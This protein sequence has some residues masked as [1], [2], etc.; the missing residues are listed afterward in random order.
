MLIFGSCNF[1]VSVK[2]F[3]NCFYL[4]IFDFFFIEFRIWIRVV[5]GYIFVRFM[6]YGVRFRL[7]FSWL[8]KVGEWF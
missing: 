1:Y 7:V 5:K 8:F 6:D 2:Y 4:L 3:Y